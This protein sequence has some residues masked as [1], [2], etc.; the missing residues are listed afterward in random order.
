MN[1][2]FDES[3][4][5]NY[6]TPNSGLGSYT[7]DVFY[8]DENSG[9]ACSSGPNNWG[10]C[11][12]GGCNSNSYGGV[13]EVGRYRDGGVDRRSGIRSTQFQDGSCHRGNVCVLDW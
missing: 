3:P 12:V 13:V 6:S 8:F 9:R 2:D 4:C 7:H 1:L 5:A 11:N 10:N